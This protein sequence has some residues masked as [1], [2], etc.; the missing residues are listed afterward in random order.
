MMK[1]YTL[2]IYRN[3]IPMSLVGVKEERR[4]FS[5]LSKAIYSRL[6]GI[7]YTT[8]VCNDGVILESD[9]IEDNGFLDSEI[10]FRFMQMNLVLHVD[11]LTW[12][13]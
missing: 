2:Q 10:P 1:V 11:L 3:G 12:R 8:R 5:T 4:F 13:I 6:P 7:E 9:C